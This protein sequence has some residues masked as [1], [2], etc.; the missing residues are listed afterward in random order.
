[1]LAGRSPRSEYR[2]CGLHAS[3]RT[4]AG[5]VS[6]LVWLSPLSMCVQE[7]STL[8]YASVVF[9]GRVC[10][11][12]AQCVATGD[13][14]GSSHTAGGAQCRHVLWTCPQSRKGL[15]ALACVLHLSRLPVFN[16]TTTTNLLRAVYG[17]IAERRQGMAMSA[18]V[19]LLFF[20]RLARPRVATA[21]NFG[22]AN[23]SRLLA[24][25]QH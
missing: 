13:C 10:E 19:S 12:I 4:V 23:R 6:T 3:R 18:E 9:E 15:V 7:R 17:A 1:M 2:S 14:V 8:Q 5:C 22:G 21:T 24:S 20:G 16:Q 11:C 25:W